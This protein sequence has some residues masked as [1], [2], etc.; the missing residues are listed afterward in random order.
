MLSE[1]M[2]LSHGLALD[3]R[4]ACLGALMTLSGSRMRRL[5]DS[6][7]S[8]RSDRFVSL[9]CK[10]SELYTD[11]LSLMLLGRLAAN[12]VQVAW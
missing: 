9:E 5:L 12:S 8:T 7:C 2:A 1:C 10:L 3:R 4:G 11:R 6:L